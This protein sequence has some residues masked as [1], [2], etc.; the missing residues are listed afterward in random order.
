MLGLQIRF[1]SAMDRRIPSIRTSG[2]KKERHQSASIVVHS[3]QNSQKAQIDRMQIP[4]DSARNRGN[5]GAR[6]NSHGRRVVEVR[7]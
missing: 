4:F 1:D 3:N 2:F 5:A 7:R 6:G